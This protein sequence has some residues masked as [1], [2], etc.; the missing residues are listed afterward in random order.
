[1]KRLIPLLFCSGVG[2]CAPVI[3]ASESGVASDIQVSDFDTGMQDFYLGGSLGLASY[4]MWD[5]SDITF[6]IF[7]GFNL[8]E[9]LSV[10]LGWIN[11][12]EVDKSATAFEAIALHKAGTILEASA[13]QAAMIGSFP[14]SNDLNLYAKLGM[15]KWDADLATVVSSA[16]DSGAD[17]FFGAGVDYQFAVSTSVR[18]SADLYALGDEDIAV[19]SVGVKQSF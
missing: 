4:D 1:M 18:F 8:N 10:E 11:F 16:S 3:A 17:V 2:I 19:Y 15:T 6:N 12:G 14:L 5:D 7:A 9:I 13:F